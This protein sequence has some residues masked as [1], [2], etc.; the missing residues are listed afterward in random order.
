MPTRLR[1]GIEM[2]DDLE[3]HRK[4]FDLKAAVQ[5]LEVPLLLVHGKED[6][7]VRPNEAQELFDAADKSRTSLVLLDQVGH[8][9]GAGS[10]FR[11]TNPT[12]EHIIALTLDWFHRHI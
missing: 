10:P 11:G 5:R 3:A 7:S 6:V 8:M 4:L 9:Y 1:Y 12:I 2:L